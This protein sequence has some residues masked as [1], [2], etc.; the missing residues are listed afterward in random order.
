M[1]P[2]WQHCYNAALFGL[3]VIGLPVIGL[4]VIGLPVIGLPVIGL[5]V[6]DIGSKK[7]DSA[8]FWGTERSTAQGC[9]A[10]GFMLGC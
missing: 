9:R 5:A 2:M 6:L 10:R 7:S 1:N 4:P 8:K 3:P